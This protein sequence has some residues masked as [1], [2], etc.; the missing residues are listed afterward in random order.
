MPHSV[1]C[2]RGC[3]PG[4]DHEGQRIKNEER[5]KEILKEE[6]LERLRVKEH[7]RLYPQQHYDYLKSKSRDYPSRF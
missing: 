2:R 3:I 6:E 5:E 1:S 4:C 7:R